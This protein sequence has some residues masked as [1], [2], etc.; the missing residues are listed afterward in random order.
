MSPEQITGDS[1]DPRS[2]LYSLGIVAYEM[3]SGAKPFTADTPVKVLFQHLEGEA[4][5]LAS[6][7]QG[8]PEGIGT[9]VARAMAKDPGERPA[10]ADTMRMEI[11]KERASL[12]ASR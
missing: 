7:V 9:L 2:D 12:E 1:V 10:S 11:E 8:L 6:R 5:P 3:F 4:E